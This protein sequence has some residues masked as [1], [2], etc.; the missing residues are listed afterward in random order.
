MTTD[1]PTSKSSG[2]YKLSSLAKALVSIRLVLLAKVLSCEIGSEVGVF[3]VVSF[4][5]SSSSAEPPGCVA[6]IG[7]EKR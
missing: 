2:T 5:R 3:P 6:I 1:F 7:R 4:C